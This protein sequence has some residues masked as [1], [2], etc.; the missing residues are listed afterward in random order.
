[1]LEAWPLGASDNSDNESALAAAQQE[2][3]V[4]AEPYVDAGKIFDQASREA[5]LK[6]RRALYVGELLAFTLDDHRKWEPLPALQWWDSKDPSGEESPFIADNDF[7]SPHY[8]LVQFGPD[9][10]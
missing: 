10:R 5:D 9:T 6:L 7:V 3:G 1:M 4:A 2:A 8:D